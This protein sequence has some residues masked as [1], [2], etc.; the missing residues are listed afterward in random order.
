MCEILTV[1]WP[2]PRPFLELQLWALELERLGIAGFGW[3]VAWLDDDGVTVVH[4]D[5]GR[6]ADDYK[7]RHRL[8]HVTSTRF[9][10]HLRRPS[11]LSTIH[12]ADTQPFYDEEQGFAF[13]H[14][15]L[16]R[17]H[18]EHR[19]RFAGRLHGAADSEVAFQML[20]ELLPRLGPAAALVEIHKLRRPGELR[21][22]PR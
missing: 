3:G 1:V 20:H 2:E 7:W 16:L 9:L 12:L 14:N 6:F 22:L 17:R 21:L 19:P 13:S 18:D 4:K 10:I 11:R 5:T 8:E 15:G